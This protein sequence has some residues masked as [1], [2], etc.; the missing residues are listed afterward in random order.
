MHMMHVASLLLAGAACANSGAEAAA[1]PP[2]RPHIIFFMVGDLGRNDVSWHREG[3]NIIKTPFLESLAKGGTQLQNYYVY[4]FCSPSRSTFL[5]GRHPSHIGQQ[6][7]MNL[8][9][10]PGI[11]CGINLKYD[12]IAKVLQRAGYRTAALGKWYAFDQPAGPRW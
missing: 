6:T 11:A 10:M 9:P 2:L 8:N 3:S 12:F 5:T 1:A 7:G 4:R